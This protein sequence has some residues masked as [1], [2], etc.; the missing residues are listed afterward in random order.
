V[1]ATVTHPTGWL[2][3]D[4]VAET[5]QRVAVPWFTPMA[6]DLVAAV[7]MAPGHI[8]LDVGTGTGLTAGLA[9]AAVG[10]DG[11]VVGVDPS[12][13]ML[14]LARAHHRIVALSGMAPGLP[15]AGGRFDAVVANLV[16]SH[17]PNLAEGLADM[18]R[19]LRPAG[20]LGVTAWGP[21]PTD[22]EDQGS[23]ADGIVASVRARCGLPSE[24]PV[25]G[26]PWEE[27][28]RSRAQLC[29]ALTG[30]GLTE[31]QARLHIYRRVFAVDDY[32]SSWG[33]LGRYLR[34]KAGED[35]WRDFCDRAA[36]SLR[37]RFGHTIGSVKQAWVAT[38]KA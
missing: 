16:L 3:Y 4:S 24:T 7:G 9:R 36:A 38:G 33:G 29:D 19:V 17:L 32:L 21:D 18:V 34:Q 12:T 35:R 13:G 5:Y 25:K 11:V 37:E 1:E 22:A 27:R 14:R 26:A 15:F 6:C 20:R 31:V 8:V 23:E 30:A 28:L 2:S 10:L